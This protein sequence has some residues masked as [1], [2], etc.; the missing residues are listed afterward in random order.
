[1]KVDFGLDEDEIMEDKTTDIHDNHGDDGLHQARTM[2]GLD[3]IDA[4]MNV[5]GIGISCT[6]SCTVQG[7][8]NSKSIKQ[9]KFST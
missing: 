3:D 7:I 5:S 9:I 6:C 4:T 2:G 1:M 8:S